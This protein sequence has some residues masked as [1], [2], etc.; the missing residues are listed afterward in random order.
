[1]ATEKPTVLVIGATG[2]TGRLI[3]KEFDR[4]PGP[5]QSP[6]LEMQTARHI[7]LWRA[8]TLWLAAGCGV[9]SGYSGG[10]KNCVNFA[11]LDHLFR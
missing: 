9:L 6:R 3:V 7:H 1:M 5:V 8:V 2:Q 10:S 4:D 11:V